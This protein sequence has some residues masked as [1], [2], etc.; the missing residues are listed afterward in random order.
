MSKYNGFFNY[1]A[2]F[3]SSHRSLDVESVAGQ[4]RGA[5]GVQVRFWCKLQPLT[6]DFI[7][8]LPIQT[9]HQP[10]P[11]F[12]HTVVPL[13]MVSPGRN[14]SHL[15]SPEVGSAPS[16]TSESVSNPRDTASDV[17][18]AN[19]AARPISEANLAISDTPSQPKLKS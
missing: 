2:T 15:G 18:E 12:D 9:Q 6:A 1:V 19:D 11:N 16:K 13:I 7:C 17:S 4:S 8:I 14:L 5:T 10:Q 3:P